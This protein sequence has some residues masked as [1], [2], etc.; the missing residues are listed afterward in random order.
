MLKNYKKKAERLADE[1]NEKMQAVHI[2]ANNLILA[3]KQKLNRYLEAEKNRL[4]DKIALQFN[5]NC[6]IIDK[7]IEQINKE[8]S[9]DIDTLKEHARG[10]L[11]KNPFGVNNSKNYH[12][13]T[14]EELS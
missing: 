6:S 2:K 7:Q 1:Y 4:N 11:F 13:T 3:E 8:L 10:K 12:Y 14:T 5:E 9:A